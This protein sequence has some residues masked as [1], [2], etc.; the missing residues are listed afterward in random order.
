[1]VLSRPLKANRQGFAIDGGTVDYRFGF[2]GCISSPLEKPIMPA[3][4]QIVVDRSKAG[5]PT[6]I[7][8]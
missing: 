8:I 3:G 4:Q 2:N 1:M 6:W 5:V 7:Y